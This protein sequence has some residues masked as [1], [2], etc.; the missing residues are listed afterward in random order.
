[1]STEKDVKAVN[2][3]APAAAVAA[4]EPNA[5][6]YAADALDRKNRLRALL[7]DLPNFD[8]SL[9]PVTSSQRRLAT[10]TSVES[11][12]QAALFAE[13]VP[14]VGGELSDVKK[15]RDKI[16]FLL[17]FEGVRE[18]ALFLLA[19]IDQVIVRE[20]VE[21]AKYAR[22]LYRMLQAYA[23]SAP[24]QRLQ[25]KIKAMRYAFGF[26]R[27]RKPAPPADEEIPAETKQ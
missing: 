26:E 3:V 13:E 10:L 21:G 27:R 8:R 24:N 23:V 18:Q 17:A 9:P 4:D 5:N 20:K 22:G 11:L 6:P 1:M 2:Q 25:S 7:E 12:E 16:N 14:N 19:D 15:L